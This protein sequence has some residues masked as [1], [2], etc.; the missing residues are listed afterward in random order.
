MAGDMSDST[1]RMLAYQVQNPVSSIQMHIKMHYYRYFGH[2]FRTFYVFYF[3]VLEIKPGPCTF[4]K[5]LY[6]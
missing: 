1:G 3:S 6:H 5:V 4:G 2:F